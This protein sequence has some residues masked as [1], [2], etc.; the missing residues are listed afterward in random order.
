M[1]DDNEGSK[2]IPP[3]TVPV[4]TERPY[5]RYRSAEAMERALSQL[6]QWQ[7][8]ESGNKGNRARD[9]LSKQIRKKFQGG[10]VLADIAYEMLHDPKVGQKTKVDLLRLLAQQG[11]AP[12]SRQPEEDTKEEA[13]P[14]GISTE[15]L[16][17]AL[18]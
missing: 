4:T 16:D 14:D 12:P 5:G 10:K 15:D 8:G 18:S 13:N 2:P 3:F 9:S 11:W 7:P 6:K 1:S 17:K